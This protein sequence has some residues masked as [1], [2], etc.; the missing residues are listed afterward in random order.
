MEAY[1]EWLKEKVKLDRRK[2]KMELNEEKKKIQILQKKS[3]KEY[4]Q[5]EKIIDH[6]IKKKAEQNRLHRSQTITRYILRF[7]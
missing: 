6:L 4:H 2:R 1:Y 7:Y 3:K 5:F